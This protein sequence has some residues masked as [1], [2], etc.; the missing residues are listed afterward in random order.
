MKHYIKVVILLY[1]S[2]FL[3]SC[4][5]DKINSKPSNKDS[6]ISMSSQ[7]NSE[8]NVSSQKSSE[9]KVEKKPSVTINCYYEEP[10]SFKDK[11]A[12]IWG[13]MLKNEYVEVIIQGKVLE[14]EYVSLEYDSA[15][16]ELIEN[17]LKGKY[18]SLENKTVVINTDLPEGIPSEK[19]KWK[20]EQGKEYEYIIRD[21]GLVDA[22]NTQ[23]VF[24]LE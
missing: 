7:T 18:S 20:S 13:G 16:N 2:L 15:T 19:I 8:A 22:K 21:Y 17:G 11:N 24:P 12:I 5:T 1:L 6:E 23:K 14:F 9:T 4:G 3:V 10:A